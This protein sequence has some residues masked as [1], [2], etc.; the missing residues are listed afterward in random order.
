MLLDPILKRFQF[1]FRGNQKTNDL[2]HPEWYYAFSLK[3]IGDHFPFL[4]LL[5]R[6]TNKKNK[7]T[8][9]GYPK[10]DHLNEFPLDPEAPEGIDVIGQFISGICAEIVDKLSQ[11]LVQVKE[12]PEIFWRT[13]NESLNFKKEL[14][15]RYKYQ[16]ESD[17]LR[18]FYSNYMDAW[19]RMEEDCT[20]R[21]GRRREGEERR[22]GRGG[23]KGMGE[24]G[25]K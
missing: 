9:R 13:L 10:K 17:P 14:R 6:V 5:Q 11:D 23:R 19:L 20:L 12:D 2:A 25:T 21:G 22:R 4:E 18:L 8:F 24:K 3:S 16:N 7:K 15:R 1:N